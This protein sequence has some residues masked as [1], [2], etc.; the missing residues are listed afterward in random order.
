MAVNNLI[1]TPL[2]VK[3]Y[4]TICFS[5]LSNAFSKFP[6]AKYALNWV[7][8]ITFIHMFLLS[9]LRALCLYNY[10]NHAYIL[11]Y[12]LELSVPTPNPWVWF[13][14]SHALLNI[15]QNSSMPI[16]PK[17]IYSCAFCCYARIL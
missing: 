3:L 12:V 17:Y 5:T 14:H 6:K 4:H 8:F 9:Y 2:F 10:N 1:S 7:F 11:F 13:L 15:F 16:S